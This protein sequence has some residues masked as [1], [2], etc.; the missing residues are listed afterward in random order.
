MTFFLYTT[1]IYSLLTLNVCRTQLKILPLIIYGCFFNLPL[2]IAVGRL[3]DACA[4]AATYLMFLPA[5]ETMLENIEF[6]KALPKFQTSMLQ[7]RTVSTRLKYSDYTW[8]CE[9]L[10][11]FTVIALLQEAVNYIHRQTYENALLKFVADEFIFP[12]IEEKD[13]LPPPDDEVN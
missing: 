11:Q 4:A 8:A 2:C 10:N 7:P 9:F 1:I 5:D 3:K 13:K 6:Y 12:E